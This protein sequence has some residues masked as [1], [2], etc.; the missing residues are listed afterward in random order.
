MATLRHSG[1]TAIPRPTPNK[2]NTTRITIMVNM[3]ALISTCNRVFRISHTEGTIQDSVATISTQSRIAV[4]PG[5]DLKPLQYMPRGDVVGI[6][7]IYNGLLVVGAEDVDKPINLQAARTS[8]GSRN[9]QTKFPSNNSSSQ[10][11]RLPS[12]KRTTILS[13]RPKTCR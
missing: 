1:K 10:S 3:R 9:H 6:F 13:D 11:H 12:L 2:A 7:R 5:L 4:T 8:R